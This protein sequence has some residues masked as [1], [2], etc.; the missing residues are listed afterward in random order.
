MRP[1]EALL[2]LAIA[3][4]FLSLVIPTLRARRR[5]G[6]VAAVAIML[7]ITQNAIEGSRWQLV[8][9]Y[10]FLGSLSLLWVAQGI[11]RLGILTPAKAHGRPLM[12]KSVTALGVVAMFI[13]V[14]LPII[15][16]VLLFRTPPAPMR[17]AP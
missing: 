13:S 11:S 3:L 1:F 17:P 9:A 5:S 10:A 7:A 8:P 14:V 4:S 2:L 6:F 16:P 15:L 12:I